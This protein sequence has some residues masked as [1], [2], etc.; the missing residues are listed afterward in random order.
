MIS[1]RLN[2]EFLLFFLFF[3]CCYS[4]RFSFPIPRLLFSY[5]SFFIF[6]SQRTKICKLCERRKK[7]EEKETSSKSKSETEKKRKERRSSES[8]APSAFCHKYICSHRRCCF[9]C[10]T[11]NYLGKDL[12]IE[13]RAP[14]AR[15]DPAQHTAEHQ[16]I[17]PNRSCLVDFVVARV[18]ACNLPSIWHRRHMELR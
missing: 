9:V 8:G 3:F 11:W 18:V 7:K 16:K 5:F 14:C 4:P 10:S 13:A 15:I 12:C 17:H 1:I 2:M 6:Y